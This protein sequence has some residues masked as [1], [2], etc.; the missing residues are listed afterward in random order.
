MK[1]YTTLR[2]KNDTPLIGAYW[3][4]YSNLKI[5]EI[6]VR[7]D[8][9]YFVITGDSQTE[10]LFEFFDYLV[11]NRLI[12]WFSFDSE[13]A[14]SSMIDLVFEEFPDFDFFISGEN[15][16]FEM[17]LFASE[18]SGNR[19]KDSNIA[20]LV[21]NDLKIMTSMD[22]EEFVNDFTQFRTVNAE[23]IFFGVKKYFKCIWQMF[24]IQPAATISATSLRAWRRT[25][26]PGIAYVRLSESN[27]NLIMRSYR[28]GVL[29]MRDN[30]KYKNCLTLDINSSYASVMDSG[31]PVGAALF[32]KKPAALPG[33]HCVSVTVPHLRV[34]ILFY[35]DK[36]TGKT[37]FYPRSGRKTITVLATGPELELALENGYNLVKYHFGIFFEMIDQPFTDFIDLCKAHRE[38]YSGDAQEKL[39]KIIQNSL[40]G[41]FASKQISRSVVKKKESDDFEDGLYSTI[42]DG[43]FIKHEK[44]DIDRMPHWASWITSLGRVKL[45]RKF[46]TMPD[47]VIYM[48]TDSIV[49]KKDDF[50]LTDWDISKK[51]GD[52]KVA[53]EWTLFQAI[54]LKKYRGELINGTSKIVSSG[55]DGVKAAGLVRRGET[56]MA[57]SLSG[58]L[59][60]V[61]RGAGGPGVRLHKLDEFGKNWADSDGEIFSRTS[62]DENMR[63]PD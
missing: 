25:I 63:E 38:K 48:D 22:A 33:F 34:P 23:S 61:L 18:R 1:S 58:K 62:P 20:K 11:Q 8:L 60:S 24:A 28:G 37:L 9:E 14:F 16:V 44:K 21:I 52:W 5:I 56:V 30:R 55:I 51:Y 35:R 12:R 10:I 7:T 4:R 32:S 29:Y 19:R 49:I 36:A 2:T 31:V 47:K 27:E 3:C 15:S 6:E 50:L 40:S 54:A 59:L 13:R 57:E 42:I 43:V 53:H 46:Y 17:R 26:P 39:A 41:K 45:L